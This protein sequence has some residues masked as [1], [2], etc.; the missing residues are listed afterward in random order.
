[1]FIEELSKITGLPLDE[2]L[3]NYTLTN[4][5]GRVVS[6]SNYKKL[7]SYHPN[8]VVLKIKNNE[9]II[10]GNNLKIAELSGKNVIIKGEIIK[11]YL[12]KGTI[13]ENV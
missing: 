11:S 4:V 12:L 1:M 5:G 9:L 13:E 7:V 3:T 2:T 10:E 8:K 6:V